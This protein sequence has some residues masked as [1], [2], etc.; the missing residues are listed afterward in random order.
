MTKR[1]LIVISTML[2]AF[3]VTAQDILVK[4]GDIALWM[5]KDIYQVIASIRCPQ[6]PFWYHADVVID[7]E[8]RISTA[9]PE[10]GCSSFSTI[11]NRIDSGSWQ[12]LLLLRNNSLTEEQIENILTIAIET[13][14]E[15]DWIGFYL[16]WLDFLFFC[17]DILVFR[18]LPDD[19]TNYNCLSF[20]A[21]C[22]GFSHPHSITPWGIIAT[23]GWETV[24]EYNLEE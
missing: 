18:V 9:T 14:C 24:G 19:Y 12:K 16:Q 8:G 23:P 15:Y 3:V 21:F 22:E 1:M 2:F 20:A 10:N 4:P 7:E 5:P 13:E 11:Q 17:D 6:L